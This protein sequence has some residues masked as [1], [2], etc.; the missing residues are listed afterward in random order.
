MP[1]EEEKIEEVKH[2]EILK[3]DQ[4]IDH[5]N[6]KGEKDMNSKLNKNFQSTPALNEKINI[7]KLNEDL[8]SKDLTHKEFK[9][10]NFSMKDAH[11][12]TKNY[13]SIEEI[14]KSEIY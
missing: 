10:L 3:I 12:D 9:P 14:N 6:E 1:L 2:N 7:T 4:I 5:Y 8:N 11:I 13:F